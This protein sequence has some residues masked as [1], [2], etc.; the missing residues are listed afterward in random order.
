MVRAGKAPP[1]RRELLMDR[2]PNAA[3]LNSAEYAS[4]VLVSRGFMTRT[5]PRTHEAR[6]V[7]LGLIQFRLG[8]LMP[9]P[10]G[11]MVAR[12]QG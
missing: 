4:L 9:T 5:I 7:A 6:L 11:R 8:G 2:M 10:A 3:D 1:Q 12:T